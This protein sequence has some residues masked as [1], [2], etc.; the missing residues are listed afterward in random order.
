[1][2]SWLEKLG[3]GL[4]KSSQKIGGGISGIFTKRK[5]DAE[6]LEEL[7]EK[8]GIVHRFLVVRSGLN[9]IEEAAKRIETL[10]QGALNSSEL[11]GL[12]KTIQETV[13]T[14]KE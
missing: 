13:D 10:N 2:I 11:A 9:T 8:T 4:K 3:L 14:L 12:V 6:T 1:M 5:L 7:E